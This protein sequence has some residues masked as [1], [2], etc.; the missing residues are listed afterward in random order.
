[1]KKDL[2]IPDKCPWSIEE[3]LEGDVDALDWR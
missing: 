2:A 1:M 3:L